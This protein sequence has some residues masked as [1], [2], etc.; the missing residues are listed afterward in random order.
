MKKIIFKDYPNTGTPI[1]KAMYYYVAQLNADRDYKDLLW[2]NA[3]LANKL[4]ENEMSKFFKKYPDELN[5]KCLIDMFGNTN[6][7]IEECEFYKKE[8]GV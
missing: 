3:E 6:I 5:R 2:L 4:Y 8:L 1:P 7:T